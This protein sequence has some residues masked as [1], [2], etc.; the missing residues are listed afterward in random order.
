LF[1]IIPYKTFLKII[2]RLVASDKMVRLYKGVYAIL[3]ES[4]NYETI[5]TYDTR[6]YSRVVVGK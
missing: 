6:D 4:G 5:E 3:D 1:K 2:E